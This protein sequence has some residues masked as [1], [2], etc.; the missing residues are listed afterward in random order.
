MRDF[1][2]SE[3]KNFDLELVTKADG[4]EVVDFLIGNNNLY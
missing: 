2:K 1:I 3:L 4:R